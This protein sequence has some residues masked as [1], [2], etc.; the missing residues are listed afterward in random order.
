MRAVIAEAPAVPHRPGARGRSLKALLRTLSWLTSLLVALPC[1][2][3]KP[4]RGTTF[5]RMDEATLM[6]SSTVVVVGTVSRI[7]S[8]SPSP[9]GPIY[10]YVHVQVD[11]VIKGQLHEGPIVLRESGGSFGG[12]HDWTFGAPEFW[13][14]ERSLLFLTRNTDGSL[15]TNNFAMGK[16]TLGVDAAGRTT[17]TRDFGAGTSVFLPSTGQFMPV[18]RETQPYIPFLS[19][20]RTLARSDTVP[21]HVSLAVIPPELSAAITEVQESFTFL[22]SPSRWF[23]PDD[24]LPVTYLIDS[25]GDSKIGPTASR[26]AIGWAF[27]AWTSVPTASLVL[28]D[29]GTTSP[30]AFAGCD[31]NR[32]VFND[33]Y[34]EVPDPSGCSGTLAIG[35]YCSSGQTRVV[36]G[37]TFNR[38]TTGKVTFNN[39]WSGCSAWN[40]INLAEVAT[41][42]IGHT[43]G[44][45]HSSDPSAT[46]FAIA[47]F[48]RRCAGPITQPSPCLGSDDIAAVTFA[49]PQVGT[50]VA[51]ATA[52]HTP[53][54]TPIPTPTN[55]FTA[56]PTPT[57]TQTP[58]LTPTHTPTS[59]LTSAPTQPPT[60]AG[61]KS[62]SVATDLVFIARQLLGLAP[63]PPSFRF[64]DPTLPPDSVVSAWVDAFGM[65]LDV[66]LD[67]AL[68][69]GTDIIYIARYELGL[70][71]VPPSFRAQDPTIPPDTVIAANI[72]A[73]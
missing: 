44:L 73:L 56:P 52:S 13:V 34:N 47:H 12:R 45:G 28:N 35:G 40:Q 61:T 54:R 63:V 49:Y 48:D 71:P 31:T 39:G 55:T 59:T 62:L 22:G 67:G 2:F 9:D 69:V 4:A 23:E 38:I 3:P 60:P 10:T 33:P 29:G 20:L 42:E 32:I 14:G 72:T 68:D 6:H 5:V 43:I 27:A 26:T 46:M 30:A 19:R 16:Y 58:T 17:A 15:R 65:K 24:G 1:F 66:D 36:N 11:R 21:P 57:A 41:H 8:A 25:T 37:T 50:P 70:P 64:A 53:S 7:E 18:R 51:T